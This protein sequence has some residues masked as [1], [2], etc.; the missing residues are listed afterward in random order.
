[1]KTE[2]RESLWYA[3]IFSCT[4]SL[5]WLCC[6]EWGRAAAIFL[7]VMTAAFFV[8][9]LVIPAVTKNAPKAVR[10][11]LRVILS[12]S[13]VVMLTYVLFNVLAAYAMFYPQFDERTYD[14]LANNV[15]GMDNFE[16]LTVETDN[17]S[18]SG[19]RI[20][21]EEDSAPLVLYFG[22]NAETASEKINNILYNG[23][24]TSVFGGCNFVMFDMP[25][26]GKSSG[27]PC[28]STLKNF[29]LAAYDHAVEKYHPS[30][31]II[32]GYSIGTGTANYVASE[33]KIDA[34]ILMAPY[35]DGVDLYN[36]RLNIFYGPLRYLVAYQ[37]ESIRFAEKIEVLPL[38]FA[39]D[40]DEVVPYQSSLRLKDAYSGGS[41]F[42]ALSGIKHAYF[43][44]NPMVMERVSNHISEV[45]EK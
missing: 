42:I 44:N 7:M 20:N 21:N 26:Y 11:I 30:K 29:G 13:V 38:I 22:G 5:I 32:I 28:E 2:N 24:D 15:I 34:L 27:Y 12:S 35:A 4:G 1:M 41:E 33:R 18:I 19:W 45:L 17:G 43:W 40:S 3:L 23:Y 14:I 37:M 39:S 8:L 36:S 31:I 6:S 16:E 10:I 25:G 9:Y